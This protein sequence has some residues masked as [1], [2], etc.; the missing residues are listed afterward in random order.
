MDHVDRDLQRAS[1]LLLATA[2]I[3]LMRD[4]ALVKI[5]WY[6]NEIKSFGAYTQH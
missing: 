2:F 4:D 1:A 3:L 6:M 5:L